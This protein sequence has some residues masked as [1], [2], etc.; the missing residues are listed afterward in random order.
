M[1]KKGPTWTVRSKTLGSHGQRIAPKLTRFNGMGFESNSPRRTKSVLAGRFSTRS[2]LHF[3]WEPTA[4][5][6]SA[7][8]LSVAR[9]PTR[10]GYR[11]FWNAGE[12]CVRLDRK[13]MG[14][15]RFRFTLVSELCVALLALFAGGFLSYRR[16]VREDEEEQW[17]AHTHRALETLPQSALTPLNSESGEDGVIITGDES[18][19]QPY[20]SG[21]ERLQTAIEELQLLTRDN[22]H[23]LSAIEKPLLASRFAEFQREIDAIRERG[24]QAFRL[25]NRGASEGFSHRLGDSYSSFQNEHLFR[26]APRL[27]L[28]LLPP[29][30]GICKFSIVRRRKMPFGRRS[31]AF[32]CREAIRLAPPRS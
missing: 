29:R 11:R 20:S 7:L 12:A 10:N 21:L 28:C 25:G 8:S 6:D 23:Q 4:K 22:P 3:E 30:K 16:A 32:Q 26:L 17:V 13:E 24:L 5:R 1:V 18:H 14:L 2:F 19:L 15:L 27:G 9:T 31:S